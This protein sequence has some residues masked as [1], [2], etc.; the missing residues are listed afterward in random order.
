MTTPEFTAYMRWKRY[1]HETHPELPKGISRTT[2]LAFCDAL[3]LSGTLGIDCYKSNRVIAI[4][5]ELK[6]HGILKAYREFV[7]S[8]GWFVP[9]GKRHRRMM[10]LDIA[11][12][13]EVEGD[14]NASLEPAEHDQSV[15]WRNC[16]ACQE[17][18][19]ERR[20]TVGWMDGGEIMALHKSG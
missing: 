12:P 19:E 15:D 7:V 2:L 13:G 1:I 4:E 14:A 11:I 9:N 3:A 5:L 10:G 17:V 18:F 6:H 20:R 8:V 16:P